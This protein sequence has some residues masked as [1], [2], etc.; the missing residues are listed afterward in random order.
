MRTCNAKHPDHPEVVCLEWL[1]HRSPEHQGYWANS[2][3]IPANEVR[4]LVV[5]SPPKLACS[6]CGCFDGHLMRCPRVFDA[7]YG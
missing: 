1:H 7:M 3:Q 6:G 2:A 4:W 5:P